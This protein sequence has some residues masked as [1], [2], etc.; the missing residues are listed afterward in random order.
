MLNMKHAMMTAALLCLPGAVSLY[1]ADDNEDSLW[2]YA[3]P[4]ADVCVYINT[5][6]AEKAMEK[7]LW[8]QIQK[9]KNEAIDKK[10]KSG[11]Q[12]FDTKNRDM[13]VIGNLHII[14][15]EPFAGT[16][17]GVAN[18]SGDLKGDLDKMM[19][20]LKEGNSGVDPQMS[21]Q[22]DMDFYTLA[23]PGTDGLS[24]LDCMVVP[25]KPNQIQFHVNFNSQDAIQKMVMG[26]TAEPSPAIQK[27]SGQDLAFA[28]ILSPEKLIEIQF[29]NEGS[30]KLVEFLKQ[31]NEIAISVRVAGKQMVIDGSLAFK[32]EAFVTEFMT[33]AEPFL[34]ELKSATGGETP[35]RMS[36]NGRIVSITI[37]VSISDAWK[38]ISNMTA[39]PDEEEVEE[40]MQK[41]DELAEKEKKKEEKGE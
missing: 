36:S 20:N 2:G 41:V 39:E 11:D 25:V 13:E 3:D 29:A 5:K 30:E 21:K 35:P 10:S 24:G 4:T 27:F 19:E 12:L 14:S 32:S 38:L 23:L 22:N 1:A 18:I 28:C 8:D 33:I 34:S 17:D 15:M 16:M 6:Q 7:N 9:D 37:P 40:A 31:M 26:K